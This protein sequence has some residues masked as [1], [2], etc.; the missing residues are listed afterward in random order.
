MSGDSGS[1]QPTNQTV[2]QTSIPK[3]FYPYLEN[4]MGKAQ[5]ISSQPYTPYPGPR[6]SDFSTDTKQSFDMTRQNVG[7][8]QPFMQTATGALG[9][10]INLAGDV[11]GMAPGSSGLTRYQAGPADQ[12]ST[13]QWGNMAMNRYMS[14]YLNSVLSSQLGNSMRAYGQ[15]RAGIAQQAEAAGAYGG[16]RQAVAEQ[17]AFKNQMDQ[18]NQLQANTL[19]QGYNTAF[20]NFSTDQARALQAQQAN[21]N[22]NLSTNQM[23][24]NANLQT[25]DLGARMDMQKAQLAL[26][27]AQ[28]QAAMGGQMAGLGQ[29]Y[30]GLNAADAAALRNQGLSQEQLN[31][32]SYDLGYQNFQDQTNWDKNNLAF[33]SSLLHGLPVGQTTTQTQ[34]TYTNPFTQMVGAGL[35]LAGLYQNM[36]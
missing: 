6:L 5:G 10:A 30:A 3:E 18:L 28:A 25:Q 33:Q 34:N 35:G 26:Q 9:G 4:I 15:D 16:S 14:P 17:M 21:Q 31:Q 19:N 27:A 12:V 24:L 1:S 2:T 36:H 32:A 23:N 13:G 22:A 7:S 20:S 8:W 11:P 29:T